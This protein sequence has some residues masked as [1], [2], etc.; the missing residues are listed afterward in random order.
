MLLVAL[1]SYSC[2]LGIRQGQWK[3]GSKAELTVLV[4]IYTGGN[5]GTAFVA[6]AGGCVTGDSPFVSTFVT[7]V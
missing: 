5:S 3:E 1:V 2:C 6:P 7:C 4:T